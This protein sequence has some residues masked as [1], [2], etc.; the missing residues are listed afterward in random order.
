MLVK[1]SLV[2]GASKQPSPVRE[3]AIRSE[4]RPRKGERFPARSLHR[5]KPRFFGMA[6]TALV[7]AG[8]SE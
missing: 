3:S 7:L 2:A 4:R 1:T 5:P 8:A 6:Y